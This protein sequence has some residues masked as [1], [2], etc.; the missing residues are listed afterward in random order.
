MFDE[1]SSFL[2]QGSDSEK[3]QM[4]LY[5]ALNHI[6]NKIVELAQFKLIGSKKSP[7]DLANIDQVFAALSFQISLDLCLENSRTLALVRTVINYH[8]RIVIKVYQ[9]IETLDT[10]ISSKPIA[11]EAAIHCLC[12]LKY[13]TERRKER[14]ED[15]GMFEGTIPKLKWGTSIKILVRKLLQNSIIQKGTKGELYS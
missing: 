2:F 12:K 5:V 8:M 11:S 15:S 7:Y 4:G 9:N 3:L 1:A 14:S 13:D 6:F 10:I